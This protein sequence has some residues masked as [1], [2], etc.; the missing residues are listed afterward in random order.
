MDGSVSMSTGM[1]TKDYPS[2][3]ERNFL[4]SLET[5]AR[6]LPPHAAT[7]QTESA[8]DYV[9]FRISPA[10]DQSAIL[11][12]EASTQGGIAFRVGRATTVELSKSNEDRFFQICE[13]VFSSHFTEFVT[14]SATGRV[15]CSRIQ[16]KIKGRK[17]RLGGHQLFW[18]LFPNRRKEQFPYKPY[19]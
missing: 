7:L 11:V 9:T 13:A 2:S 3:F 6:A 4:L 15:L 16:L 12:G 10:N 17:V 1:L 8:A 19:Y 5:I 18:W 14:Y